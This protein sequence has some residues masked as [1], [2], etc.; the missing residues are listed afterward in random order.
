MQDYFRDV[1]RDDVRELLPAHTD[2][3]ADPALLVPPLGRSLAALGDD[4]AAGATCATQK[5]L[6]AMRRG[7]L[8]SAAAAEEAVGAGPASA[9]VHGFMNC[10]A[11]CPTIPLPRR[12]RR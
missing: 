3:L 8:Q 11:L 1:T 12:G 6:I 5:R 10:K 9:P 7:T 2:P 4:A